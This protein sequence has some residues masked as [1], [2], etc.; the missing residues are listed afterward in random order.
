MRTLIVLLLVVFAALFTVYLASFM[1]P[2][3]VG[4]HDKAELVRNALKGAAVPLWDFARPFLQLAFLILVLHAAIRYFGGRWKLE[5]LG[6]RWDIRSLIAIVVV[7]VFSVAALSGSTMT[8]D[9]KD[10]ALVVIGFYFG[11]AGS[12][13]LGGGPETGTAANTTKVADSAG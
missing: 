7:S 2:D 5:A 4:G 9:L 12:K 6:I 1:H 3:I 11:Q 8:G 13:L 10:V